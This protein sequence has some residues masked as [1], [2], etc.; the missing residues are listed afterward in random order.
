M[1]KEN[2]ERKWG[3]LK[4]LLIGVGVWIIIISAL[5]FFFWPEEKI[6]EEIVGPPNAQTELAGVNATKNA[7]AKATE[8]FTP[9]V[10]KQIEVTQE[11]KSSEVVPT[12]QQSFTQLGQYL[13]PDEMQPGQWAYKADD[14]EDTCWATT[15][16]DLSGSHDSALDNFYSENKGFFVLNNNVKMIEL[17]YGP[18]TWT[19]IGD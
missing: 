6:E 18:C 15:Y 19:R 7:Q 17:K 3:C 10:S 14:P 16:S 8:T 1:T 2:S 13:V 9:T 4:S 11:V 12:A 5:L